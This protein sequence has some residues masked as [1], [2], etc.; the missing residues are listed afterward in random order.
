LRPRRPASRS[1]GT[2][3][4]AATQTRSTWQPS[5]ASRSASIQSLSQPPVASTEKQ[6]ITH[7]TPNLRFDLLQPAQPR[8]GTRAPVQQIEDHPIGINVLNSGPPTQL[9]G[10]TRLTGALRPVEHHD[11]G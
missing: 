2:S 10:H 3:S 8:V 7:R 6:T 11:G 1:S 4:G 9:I 5:A